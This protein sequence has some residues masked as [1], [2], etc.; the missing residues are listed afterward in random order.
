MERPRDAS[1]VDVGV[2]GFYGGMSG[3]DYVRR[4]SAMTEKQGKRRGQGR[5]SRVGQEELS[6][7]TTTVEGTGPRNT[8]EGKE[9]GGIK[10]KSFANWVKRKTQAT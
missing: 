8:G 7:T 1:G 5:Q 2:E 9:N 4:G 10:K 6:R 3:E